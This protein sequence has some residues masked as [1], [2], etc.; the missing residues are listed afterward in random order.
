MNVWCSRP[1]LRI[2]LISRQPNYQG[3][4]CLPILYIQ[5]KGLRNK[6]ARGFV[7]PHPETGFEEI[8]WIISSKPTSALECAQAYV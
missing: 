3:L 4:V 8:D 6:T 7:Q 2:V 1:L 5:V